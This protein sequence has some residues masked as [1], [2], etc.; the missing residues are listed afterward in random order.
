MKVGIIYRKVLSY[1]LPTRLHRGSTQCPALETCCWGQKYCPTS[2]KLVLLSVGCGTRA[3]RLPVRW[4]DM[5]QTTERQ[6][7]SVC[8]DVF[9]AEWGDYKPLPSNT[10]RRE[11]H[12]ALINAGKNTHT[13]RWISQH[14]VLHP[15]YK[16]Q[17]SYQLSSLSEDI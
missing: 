14:D 4:C 12:A 9:N 17:L 13:H 5:R 8:Q 11:R 1:L 3:L 16:I 15:N 2:L 10:E 7:S 6:R